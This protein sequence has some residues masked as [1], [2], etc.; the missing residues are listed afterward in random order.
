VFKIAQIVPQYCDAA[1]DLVEF[2]GVGYG[3]RQTWDFSSNS[4]SERSPRK[5]ALPSLTGLSS[6]NPYAALT[7]SALS[8]L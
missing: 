8:E 2:L 3:T 4:K 6:G 1:V 7:L 5:K